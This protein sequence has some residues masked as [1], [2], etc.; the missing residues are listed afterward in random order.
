MINLNYNKLTEQ[1]KKLIDK[2][3]QVMNFGTDSKNVII[4]KIENNKIYYNFMGYNYIFENETEKSITADKTAGAEKV[5]IL[6]KIESYI[7][8]LNEHSKK[9]NGAYNSTFSYTQGKKDFKIWQTLC[10]N[11]KCIFAFIDQQGN[12]Y[13]PNGLNSK[14]TGVRGNL[15]AFKPLTASELYKR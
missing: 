4:E 10:N 5:E 12:I 1:E 2:F 14:A 8:E 15:N 9:E 3:Y 7:T 11:Q 13:K 6:E